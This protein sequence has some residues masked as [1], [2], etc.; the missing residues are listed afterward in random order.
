MTD[1]TPTTAVSV[2]D[3]AAAA[4]RWAELSAGIPV[5]SDDTSDAGARI[6]ASVFDATA[7]TDLDTAW[8][9]RD[10]GALIDL[11]VKVTALRKAI[12][13]YGDGPGFYLICDV[14][15]LSTG[16]VQVV[17]TGAVSVMAQLVKAHSAGWLPLACTLRESSRPSKAGYRPQHLEILGVAG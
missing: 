13:D 9:S 10:F 2:T 1:S 8:E 4:Q 14:V 3:P 7:P 17:T 6:A 12:S 5:A 15:D 16:E 11:P